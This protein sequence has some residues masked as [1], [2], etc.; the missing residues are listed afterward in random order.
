MGGAHRFGGAR[1]TEACSWEN[2]LLR[3]VTLHAQ[4]T[5]RQRQEGEGSPGLWGFAKG[6]ADLDDSVDPDLV[7]RR[8]SIH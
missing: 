3:V 7:D 4:A 8:L 6:H 1:E 2:R 5:R